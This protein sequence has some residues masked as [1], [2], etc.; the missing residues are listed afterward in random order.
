MHR[1]GRT[2][3]GFVLR[4]GLPLPARRA[5]ELMIEAADH[6]LA[7][8]FVTEVSGLAA[9]TLTAAVAAR[10]PTVALGT[11]VVPLGSR[12]LA[13]VAMTAATN[14][15]LSDAPYRLG[16]GVST[17]AIV[18]GW[19]GARYTASL[20]ETRDQLLELRS[21]LD[22]A[23]RG[24]FTLV[25]PPGPRV[26]LLLGALGPR[27]VA[28]ASEVADGVVVSYTPVD[29]LPACDGERYATVWVSACDDAAIRARRELTSYA[30]A[31]SYGRHFRRLGYGAAVDAIV[32]LHAEGRLREGPKQIPG[33]LVDRLLV[34]PRDL[35]ERA[36]E[37]AAQDAVPLVLPLTGTDPEAELTALLHDASL[38]LA[39]EDTAAHDTTGSRPTRRTR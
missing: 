36:A 38:D 25:D 10:R 24:S 1:A 39:A 14:A 16:V 13:A 29:A 6:G 11:A 12:S 19:H 15:S 35:A 7:P 18:E 20:A 31:P 21:L 30:V 17:P 37:V 9:P 2:E 4:G 26:R 33:E 32:R 3:L 23:S 28:M 5:A 34:A 22:G 27:M 8:L